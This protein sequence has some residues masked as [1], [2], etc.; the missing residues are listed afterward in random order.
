MTSQP[1]SRPTQPS[2][3]PPRRAL[4]A[5]S[6]VLLAGFA[7]AGC[8]ENDDAGNGALPP[9]MV[10]LTDLP[11]TT[12]TITPQ[13][14]LVVEGTDADGWAGSTEDEAIASFTHPTQEG[15]TF[16]SGFQGHAEGK[17]QAELTSPEG[18]ITHFTIVV[19][20]PAPG[21]G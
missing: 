12:V 17:T 14:P 13:R 3:P 10:T 19:E 11:G 21:A 5:L 2:T 4:A 8:G 15:A 6:A 1:T 18:E 20:A 16:N 9:V 7:L